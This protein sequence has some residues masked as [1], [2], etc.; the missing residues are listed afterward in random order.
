M[1]KR[2]D[3][4]PATLF[5]VY[6][7][8]IYA[9]LHIL[10]RTN[11]NATG[12]ADMRTTAPHP[13]HI[14][15]VL[16]I[17][18]L[19]AGLAPAV[20]VHAQGNGI[21][22]TH[23]R[24]LLTNERLNRLRAYACYDANG[25]V[26]SP[27]QPTAEW[28]Q[29]KNAVD[30]NAKELYA[31]EAALVYKVT[32]DPAYL[33]QAIALADQRVAGG[34]QDLAH[35]HSQ[36]LHARDWMRDIAMVYDWLYDELDAAHKTS[37]VDFMNMIMFLSWNNDAESNG[38]YN[39]GNFGTK[40]PENNFYW[41]FICAS[42]Y[43]GV[44]MY[45]E[46][47]STF[48]LDGQTYNFYLPSFSGVDFDNLVDFV[49]GKMDL[50]AIPDWLST[51]ARGGGW[52]EGNQYGASSKRHMFEAFLVLAE[53]GG[54]NYFEIIDFPRETVYFN[55]FATQPG[56]EVLYAGGK[57]GRDITYKLYDYDR[58]LM[59][60]LINGYH[61][62]IESEFAQ[63]Y[64]NNFYPQ[65]QQ[66]FLMGLDFLLYRPE[67]AARSISELPLSYYAQGYKWVNSRSSWDDD[68]ISVSFVSSD[69]IPEHQN[70]EQ[71][72]FQI[73]KGKSGGTDQDGWMV[74][75]RQPFT[76][77]KLRATKY[78]NTLMVDRYCQRVGDGTGYIRKYEVGQGYMYVVGD[79][80]DAYY[81]DQKS[82]CWS[83]TG[84]KQLHTFL[85]ELIHILPNYVVVYDRISPV[86]LSA[87]IVNYFHY[88]S[89]PT[90]NGNEIVMT[91]QHG[92]VFQ[93]VLLPA[94]Y[95]LTPVSQ[96]ETWRVEVSEATNKA[97]Y[98]QLS[99][100]QITDSGVQS[101]PA[102][103]SRIDATS[104]NMVGVQ[105][106]MGGESVV[107]MFSTDPTGGAPSG[108]VSFDVGATDNDKYYLLGLAGDTAYTVDVALVDE[109]TR[110]ISLAP[111][112]GKTTTAS[113]TLVF[114]V[115]ASAPEPRFAMR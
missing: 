80:S 52:H 48:D 7:L 101:P 41:N 20:P 30:S 82:E 14:T 8:Q 115:D 32:Q 46:E 81:K 53:A 87:E 93:T 11:T 38:I 43:A 19:L 111:G 86:E 84:T 35:V 60:C 62:Q 106:D 68:A 15:P 78:H 34:W 66:T 49:Y 114:E 105:L 72:G 18:T 47:R 6:V 54:K 12:G 95:T 91:H 50:K 44:A 1:L 13:G 26:I 59:L 63:Y 102:A 42:A 5:V 22:A 51:Y 58:H 70:N 33:Q 97:N 65:M 96:T 75:D 55:I 9:K 79:A 92:K 104:N 108:T 90:V 37:Y 73:Y 45:G 10:D 94:N 23:P 4:W 109:H 56:G 74:T 99:V 64:I 67:V 88:P 103:L 76:E 2:L 100:I 40:A 3:D 39:T 36:F 21:K 61:G 16:L 57:A 85:R 89:Q 98:L 31:Y 113:G 69:K 28:Q 77:G 110:R 112:A 17:L 27:C 71:N 107:L 25:N 83:S 29:L 24:I